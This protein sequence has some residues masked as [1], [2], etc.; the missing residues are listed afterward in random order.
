[1]DRRT[2]LMTTAATTAG[3]AIL[4][5]TPQA[6]A[7]AEAAPGD[8][9]P[10]Q[11]AS[12]ASAGED[13]PKVGGDLG[14]KNYSRLRQI[15]RD[16]VNQ[17][18]GAWHIEL[19]SGEA[20]WQE[21]TVVAQ[22]GVLYLGTTQQN[23]FAVN[24]VTGAVLWKTPVGSPAS[25]NVVRGVAIGQGLVFTI[26]GTNSAY[27]LDQRTGSVVWQTP[28][29]NENEG[30]ITTGLLAGAVVYWDG[31]IYIGMRESGG[32]D[33]GHFYALDAAT[34]KVVW[35]F[36]SCP[37]PG[38]YGNDTWA[39]DSW[40]T[41]EANCWMHPAIDPDLGLVYQTFGTPWP[42]YDGS[43]REGQNLFSA[44]LVA[45]DAKTGERQWH[46]QS[47]HHDLWDYDNVIPPVL[48]NLDIDGML[49]K[50]V[51]YGSK[52][53]QFYMLDRATGEPVQGM[54]EMP[55]PQDP[56]MNTW[57]TQ[58]V[59]GG[60]PFV[61]HLFPS[62]DNGTRPVPF[63]QCGAQFTPPGEQV[64]LPPP[65]N[66]PPNP[67]GGK[68]PPP[69][70]QVRPVII[71]PGQAG[72]NDWSAN[73]FSLDTGYVYVGYSLVNSYYEAAGDSDIPLGTDFS[74]GL[75]AV[76][77]R[78]NT[79]VWRQDSKWPLSLGNGILSTAGRVLFQGRPDG[80]LA[81]MDDETGGELWTW[82][83]GA[84]AN[85]TPISYEVG[86]EQ[87]IAILAGGN[88]GL[89]YANVP[90]GSHLWAFKLG[91][92]V[93]PAS[94]PTPPNGR[95]EP[96]Q[97]P[98]PGA[99]ANNTVTLGRDWDYG[100]GAP[101]SL[102]DILSNAA[103]APQV[104]TISAGT[105]VTFTNPAD[106]SYAHGAVSFFENEFDSG[107]LMPSQSFQ[108]TFATPGEYFYNDPVFPANTGKIVVQLA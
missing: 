94:T 34:G 53:G 66:P 13:F 49:R 1:M 12:L 73:S 99:A 76:D 61:P 107:V 43:G 32:G 51:V 6:E 81:A 108:H 56:A 19:E 71:Y 86:G 60:E 24:Q 45:L 65:I 50:V 21:C 47:V 42:G 40:Q 96:P 20:I 88:A 104:M 74:G 67:K 72:G 106:N 23:V 89:P 103:M 59:P 14:N 79:V 93:G 35:T 27:G 90:V 41:G 4:T 69:P 78:S 11:P 85:T 95:A 64:P 105:V 17:L 82:Q 38:E 44:C 52:S 10:P 102:E 84:G 100:S 5:V 62:Y 92:T 8:P 80:T 7:A 46:F 39:G 54:R 57:P 18:G 55:V 31:L 26:S 22:D 77:P 9:V 29:L 2:F 98:V 75:A 15:T 68:P 3:A 48:I 97:S 36:W 63:Y 70:V 37:A 25:L 87:Y 30:G 91:G 33:R 16:N 58:P 28:L 101:S 83:C